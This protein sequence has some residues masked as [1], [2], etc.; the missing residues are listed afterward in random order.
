MELKF[1]SHMF[2]SLLCEEFVKLTLGLCVSKSPAAVS[3]LFRSVPAHEVKKLMEFEAAT[4]RP[5]IHVPG[6]LL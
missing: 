2:F 1:G 3:Y 6:R 5:F 4:A